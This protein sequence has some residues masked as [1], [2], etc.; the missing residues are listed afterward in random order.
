MVS[1]MSIEYYV[2]EDIAW[3]TLK[4]PGVMTLETLRTLRNSIEDA[5]RDG[6][7]NFI[8]VK[9]SGRFF[10]VGADLKH[11][12]D[13]DSP[14]DAM[15][16]FIELAGVFKTLLN[17]P[18]ITILAYNGDAYGGGSELLWA[19]DLSVAVR[20]VRLVWPEAKWGLIPPALSTIGA[21]LVGPARASMLALTNGYLTAEELHHIGL[22]SRL[23]D[24]P[25]ML[26]DAVRELIGLIRSSSPVA[27]KEVIRHV[28]ASK[29]VLM[30]QLDAAME[31]LARLSATTLARNSALLFKDRKEPSYEWV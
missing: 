22:I 24:R 15:Q 23:V 4:S 7:V 14:D 1:R 3:I 25:D 5:G 11:V 16:L 28:R 31:T 20:G 6:R 10:S 27:A 18:K 17:S 13:A 19:A 2:E 26:D 30:K 9:G 21:T 29:L 12:A 8:V